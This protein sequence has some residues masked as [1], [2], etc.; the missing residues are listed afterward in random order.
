MPEFLSSLTYWSWWILAVLFVIVEILAPGA[1][2]LWL[3]LA[4]AAVGFVVLVVPD[5]IWQ[6][7]VAIFAVLSVVS[8]VGGR[9]YL[10][11]NPL[12]TEDSNLNRRGQ[13]YVGRVFT[14]VEP[15]VNGTGK[16]V[17][18]DTT[19]KIEGEDM[20]AGTRVRVT[21]VDGTSLTV[22][23]DESS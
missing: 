17:V 11:R 12:E 19:W 15:I 7:Q 21:G 23:D 6:A 3:G 22:V 14:L 9:A 20:P 10:R 18:D 1:H 2:F 13:Q 16:L 5:M 4:A 8:V